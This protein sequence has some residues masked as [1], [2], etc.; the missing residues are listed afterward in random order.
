MA[1]LY[2]PT[3]ISIDPSGTAADP[4]V[5]KYTGN[6]RVDAYVNSL[7]V[8]ERQAALERLTAPLTG[9]ELAQQ[10]Q[11][12]YTPTVDEFDRIEQWHKN[13]E[14]NIIEGIGA[15]ISQVMTDL[16]N[17]VGATVDHP[18]DVLSK[19]PAN[20]IEA[21]AQGTRNFYGMAAQSADPSSTLFRFKDFLTGSGTRQS[22]YE[23]YLDAL[24][25]NRSSAELME[26]K[27]TLIMDADMI[28]PEVVQAASYIADPTL[29]IPFGSAAS[30][31]L[32]A[33]GMGEKMMA[34]G[35]KTSMIKNAVVG[36]AIKW[37]VGAPVEFLGGAVRNT[38]DFGIAQ[39]SNALE[40]VTGLE[41][42]EIA[43]TLRLSGLPMTAASFAGHSI[44]Y[45]SA[46]SET[47]VGASAAKGIGEAVSAI[48]DRML[49]NKQF[50][51]G[52]NS[53]ARDA[54][55]NTPNLSNHAKGV[56]RV[57]DA[58]D[59]MFTY[60]A[61]I[62]EGAAQGAMIGG[63]LG[64][65]SGGEEGFAQ[66]LGAGMALGGVGGVAGKAVADV[67]NATLYS[68]VAIQRKIVIE[69]LKV[70]DPDKA[71]AFEALVR[72]AEASGDRH[73]QAHID[74]M[75]AGIDK[76]A[77]NSKWNVRNQADHIKWLLDEGLDPTTGKLAEFRKLLPEFG[78]DRRARSRALGFLS[79]VGDRFAGKPD[80][81]VA[82]LQTLPQDHALRKAFFRMTG[83]QKQAVMETLAKHGD[84]EYTKS[85]GGKKAADFYGD[86]NYSEINVARVNEL[87]AAGDIAGAR[88]MIDTFLKN[89]TQK[90]GSLNDRGQM[91]KNRL[92][93]EGYFDKDGN[94]RPT[95]NTDVEATARD[96]ASAEGFVLRRGSNGQVEVNIN[97]SNLGKDGVA[98]ELF[99]AIFKES[100]LRPDFIDRLSKEL[101]GTFDK[102]GKMI[103]GGSVGKNEIREFF[104][105]Y[106]R[107]TQDTEK[108]FTDEM[109]RLESAIKEF[110]IGSEAKSISPDAIATLHQYTEEFGAYYFQNWLR[111]QS[112]DFLFKGGELT[113][114]RGI[115]D[116]VKNG[117]LDFWES[118]FQSKD[119]KFNFG[120]LAEGKIDEGFKTENGKRIRVSSL[121]YFNRDFIR[122]TA[123]TNKG[124]FDI[125]KLSQQGQAE[126]VTANGIRNTHRVDST[127][128]AVRLSRREA[129][130]ANATAGKEIYKI[131][132]GINANRPT[133]GDGNFVGR[134]SDAEL[135]A[136]VKSGH[137]NR[138]W[139][140][141][142][143]MAY[144]VL[145]GKQSNVVE[146]G[147]LGRTEQLTDASYPRL[148]GDDV[149][150]KNRKA[151]LLDVELKV[152][153]NGTFHTLFHTLDKS[154]IEA[155]GN[156]L[157]KDSAVQAMWDGNRG[158]MEQDFFRYL[159]N[160]SKPDHDLSKR[161]SHELWKDGKGGQRRDVLHQ[162][163]G[164]AKGEGDTYINKP[165]SEIPLGI[166]HSVTTFNN[167]GVSSFRVSGTERYNYN[168]NNA[169]KLLSRNWKPS[170]M[171][172]QKTPVG[173]IL[174][175]ATG[176]KFVKDSQ[177]QVRAFS[178]VGSKIGTFDSVEKAAKAG[179]KHFNDALA[180]TDEAVRT[181]MKRQ[182]GEARQYKP[183]SREARDEAIAKGDVF[184]LQ[185]MK[186]FVGKRTLL[187]QTRDEHIY[188]KALEA[189]ENPEQLL[190]FAEQLNQQNAQV[191]AQFDAMD[192]QVVDKKNAFADRVR[193]DADA[194]SQAHHSLRKKYGLVEK[195]ITNEAIDK[196]H[197]SP[198]LAALREQGD[199]RRLLEL[200][201][202]K[203][204]GKEEDAVA[205]FKRE[206]IEAIENPLSE[207]LEVLDHY[208]QPDTTPQERAKM[209][210]RFVEANAKQKRYSGL[211]EAMFSKDYDDQIQTGKPFVAVTTHGTSQVELIM[212]RLFMAEK[213]GTNFNIPSSNLG[214]FSAGSQNTS[215]SYA[216]KPNNLSQ[217]FYHVVGRVAMH[218]EEGKKLIDSFD[219]SIIEHYKNEYK[220]NYPRLGEVSNKLKEL[221]DN[222]EKIP[223]DLLEEWNKLSSTP[224][225][226]KD[227]NMYAT[228]RRTDLLQGGNPLI[229][230]P[231]GFNEYYNKIKEF[232]KSN[233]IY[234]S[235]FPDRQMQLRKVIRMDN[236]YVV[237]DPR[238]YEEHFISPHMKRAI[239]DGHDGII[240]KRFAD[241]GERD[242][243]YVVFKDYMKD[244]IKVLE[245]S[246]DDDAVPRGK[247]ASGRV[248][249]GGKELGL[250]FKPVEWINRDLMNHPDNKA[251]WDR[252]MASG[253]V[254]QGYNIKDLEGKSV[255]NISPDNSFVGEISVGDDLVM[256]GQ[257]GVLFA[258]NNLEKGGIW[259]S[260]DKAA[261]KM[262]DMMTK[263]READ[264]AKGGD[265]TVYISIP[266]S[267]SSKVSSSENGARGYM[268]V[269]NQLVKHDIVSKEI[270]QAAIRKT[271]KSNEGIL[272]SNGKPISLSGSGEQITERVLASFFS[273]D[274]KSFRARGTFVKNLVTEITKAN[275]KD[276][277]KLADAQKTFDTNAKNILTN[278]DVLFEN[279]GKLFDDPLTKGLN[280][281]DV[282]AVIKVSGEF[283]IESTRLHDSYDTTI[284]HKGGEKDKP[285]LLLLDKP[286]H[287]TDLV[288]SVNNKEMVS[289]G[290]FISNEEFNQ[291][292]SQSTPRGK[293]FAPENEGGAQHHN[294]YYGI[295]S[296]GQ[297]VGKFKASLK[298][299]EEVMQRAKEAGYGSTV[300][301]HGTDKQFTEFNAN[302]NK[303]AS[304]GGGKAGY[305]FFTT[306]EAEANRY[307]QSQAGHN[308]NVPLEDKAYTMPVFLKTERPFDMQGETYYKWTEEQ[309]KQIINYI[310]SHAKHPDKEYLGL[311]IKGR[312]DRKDNIV[313]ALQTYLT[314]TERAELLQS[315]GFDGVQ[316][317]KHIAVFKPEQIKSAK[318]FTY[319]DAGVEI[320][321]SERFD[322]TKKD[323]RYKPAESGEEG[324]RTYKDFQI[325][326]R[327]IG[328]YAQENQN[329]IKD[330]NI[331]YFSNDTSDFKDVTDTKWRV[332]LK[333]K[334]GFDIGDIAFE[335]EERGRFFN[336]TEDVDGLVVS[337]ISVNIRQE[338]RGKN[339]QHL[340]YSEMF[341][342]ARA[343][344]A[345]GFS[346]NIEN[347]GGLPL[348]SVNKIV[349]KDGSKIWTLRDYEAVSPTQENFDRLMSNAP[350]MRSGKG[351]SAEFVQNNGRL[352]PNARYKP[353]E[354]WRDWNSETTSVGS[355]I[356][357]TV[358][359]LIMV[360]GDKFKV[361]NP[362]K[363]M[364]GIYTNLD[365]AKR[366]VQ[367][368]EPK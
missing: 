266:V 68:R 257:G 284:V 233:N 276:P 107:L 299:R 30:A 17:A 199:K 147:Y 273:G 8:E 271:I 174:N 239:A 235:K 260:S 178:S 347:K 28:N 328:K 39:G 152:G 295:N 224:L 353:A 215:K 304:G 116:G 202:G 27:K 97:I 98:H 71:M 157:W 20:V 208:H 85:F 344:G 103:K 99:H 117:W 310:T 113:G 183:L 342:R 204:L 191:K 81:L 60:G 180:K 164:M 12:G 171:S 72:T 339:Y 362:S 205:L 285:Q 222:G 43:Q 142:L 262:Y 118:T 193:A 2:A 290:K 36:G 49:L 281:G 190:A 46:I 300:F 201:E 305:F 177:S 313:P 57:L 188:Q 52:I 283:G 66:G 324:G 101:L 153:E 279:I 218:G 259:A 307:S 84:P 301:Y 354:G 148:Y 223:S 62:T 23:Q 37:G 367:R 264:I 311:S 365:Q 187:R 349:G 302:A 139:A 10:V 248:L 319:D 355:V 53:W 288:D 206:N 67:T 326:G 327:F 352:D 65:L 195:D 125:N 105:R 144:D 296:S 270:L 245:T 340:L 29:F 255:L 221:R 158:R 54:F 312:L 368:D 45:G 343:T 209:F 83:E 136:I 227:E 361:Y 186:D 58:V 176:Y 359:Y 226:L 165:I 220:T 112:P 331:E 203:M 214:A 134:L 291:R 76:V 44:P 41:A 213:L 135:D 249:K 240:F 95:R 35:A 14:V 246:F 207:Q 194:Y 320:P 69:G 309:K 6:E 172:S 250:Q 173:E 56:L 192:R 325:G 109:A 168:H 314:R 334:N 252:I 211:L 48:G 129:A 287:I 303:R 322:K 59:P 210:A 181:E 231:S 280:E 175:H 298:P 269:I 63:G 86:I 219:N 55:E 61:A 321:L 179:E 212:S 169:Y 216:R 111:A 22:R 137:V 160:A 74:G 120:K 330:L 265:G 96:W 102:D 123:D 110:E 132:K 238:S 93:T 357:N 159:E 315:L 88:K 366:R 333:D 335:Y 19:S 77:P 363:A 230:L 261:K 128:R 104:R 337:N 225:Y 236:P 232:A 244:N 75:I 31:G 90:D 170:E 229:S 24:K 323:I 131:L 73:Y 138:A 277:N 336:G 346:Q 78:S 317:G 146:F 82:H 254:V 253:S 4:N 182:D 332:V 15:G 141:K 70:L 106:V 51:R 122:A 5:Q 247:D 316:D 89:N 267:K 156:N 42:K 143:K 130:R 133:D 149:S 126:F 13:H 18:F 360:N 150:F 161:P 64:Y 100:V 80:D 127:G 184:L 50:G 121:D 16:S 32:R 350:K 358:G 119:P 25:F 91:L 348:K 26:G 108:G 272:D 196:Y 242:N 243:V 308:R 282:Y 268:N 34:I 40:A 293:G 241:G 338:H 124:N 237:V 289:E 185:E 275:I 228:V 7:P 234:E 155:R 286:R 217:K 167:D 94:L 318:D 198:E 292:L 163:L 21:F 189:I 364:V 256:K 341:E 356:K 251:T 11:Q 263:L 1:D 140:N 115:M 9:E 197:S 274:N 200:E 79:Q 92:G 3:S 329:I 145:D 151:I 258:V 278:S 87:F 294:A 162:M 351:L 38:I 306:D 297:A 345:I 33:V 114:V 166:R 154:V 47:Y